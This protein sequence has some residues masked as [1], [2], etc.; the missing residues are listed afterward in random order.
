MFKV[1]REWLEGLF[2]EAK[3]ENNHV[4]TD[5]AAHM[6]GVTRGTI[7]RWIKSNKIEAYKKDNEWVVVITDETT[8]L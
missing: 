8:P 4:S 5:E 1:F 3:E 2:T 7:Y 6:Y